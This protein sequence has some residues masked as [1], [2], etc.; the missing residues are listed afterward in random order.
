MVDPEAKVIPAITLF[1]TY[2]N[3]TAEAEMHLGAALVS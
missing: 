3:V 2:F 1:L